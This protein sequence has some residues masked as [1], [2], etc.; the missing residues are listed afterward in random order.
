MT[1]T[2]TK[3]TFPKWNPQKITLDRILDSMDQKDAWVAFRNSCSGFISKKN[4]Q[5]DHIKSVI[6]CF[7]EGLIFE[8][9]QLDNLQTLCGI[10]NTSKQP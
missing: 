8:C 6:S 3:V 9:N 4:L 10:C 7:K 2:E 5:V 1:H